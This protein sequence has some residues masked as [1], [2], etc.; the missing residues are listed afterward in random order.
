MVK[1]VRALLLR[2][3]VSARRFFCVRVLWEYLRRYPP[4][5]GGSLFSGIDSPLTDT[6]INRILKSVA[7]RLRLDPSRLVPHGLRVAGPVQLSCFA[8]SVR[9]TQGN[10]TSVEGMLAYARGSLQHAKLVADAL[11]DPSVLPLDLLRLSYTLPSAVSLHS[12]VL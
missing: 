11:H 9:M 8:D 3:P 7:I 12:A 2:I 6:L 5:S 4:T 1:A 10:W